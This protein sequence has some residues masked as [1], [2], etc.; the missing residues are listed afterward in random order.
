MRLSV[1]TRLLNKIHKIKFEEL[2]KNL[3]LDMKTNKGSAGQIIE[4][5]LG[6]NSNSFLLDFEDGE[7]KTNKCDKFGKPLET[8]FI[9]QISKNFDQLISG[10]DNFE[11]SNLYKKIK[12]LLYVSICKDSKD[13]GSWYIYNSYNINILK[14]NFLFGEIKNDYDN[15][16]IKI[17]SDLK[18]N[19]KMIHTSSGRFIQ[20]RSKD[21]KPYH[22]IYSKKLKRYISNKNHAFYFKKEFMIYNNK[23]K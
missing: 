1:A 15:I 2:F 9:T 7:L 18:Q 3:P 6:L 11:T 14:N 22:P 16:K 23:K 19:D 4:K 17:V 8:M 10:S 20:I 12:N 21:S 13:R 5:Y